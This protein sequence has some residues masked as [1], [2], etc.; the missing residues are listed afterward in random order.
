M[1]P[2][3]VKERN[4]TSETPIAP[5]GVVRA[6]GAITL[7]S[8]GTC[9]WAYGPGSVP[10]TCDMLPSTYR[11]FDPSPTS[12]SNCMVRPPI[13]PLPSPTR[14]SACDRVPPRH[15]PAPAATLV[16]T[17]ATSRSRVT[18]RAGICT[19]AVMEPVTPPLG[20]RSGSGPAKTKSRV[21]GC[22]SEPGS[23]ALGRRLT[24]HLRP[25]HLGTRLPTD[26]QYSTIECGFPQPPASRRPE[27]AAG[28]N[29]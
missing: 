5:P 2:S 11:D 8:V 19:F 12:R 15:T 29:C 26:G 20:Q 25:N 16:A 7:P 4:H 9:R 18:N 21:S 14:D 24:R 17:H 13:T 10:P 3:V 6:G 27:L 28:N 23:T 1:H 22:G